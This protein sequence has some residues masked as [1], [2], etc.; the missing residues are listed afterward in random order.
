MNP[1]SSGAPL[2]GRPCATPAPF[3][4]PV[5][6]AFLACST[7][8]TVGYL[9]M[10]M[11][12]DVLAGTDVAVPA[13]YFADHASAHPGGNSGQAVQ[14]APGAWG[15]RPDSMKASRTDRCT[16]TYLPSLM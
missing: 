9:L 4:E 5:G 11:A 16:R 14:R 6:V 3:P 1:D 12:V 10:D 15:T 7:V 2:G 13:V 8:S